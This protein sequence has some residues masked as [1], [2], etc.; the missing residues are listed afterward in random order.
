MTV[1]L[2]NA[3]AQLK[4]EAAELALDADGLCKVRKLDEPAEQFLRN[5]DDARANQGLEPIGGGPGTPSSPRGG[6]DVEVPGLG[7]VT[8]DTV[9]LFSAT[10]GLKQA[11]HENARAANVLTLCKSTSYP[12]NAPE[13]HSSRDRSILTALPTNL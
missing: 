9:D 10:S 1:K 3:R 6:D 7:M 12:H 8:D 2:R 5:I 4:K 11:P 13:E